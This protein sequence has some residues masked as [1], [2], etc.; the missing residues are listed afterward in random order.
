[1]S[2]TGVVPYVASKIQI[3]LNV[4]L[5]LLAAKSTKPQVA[6]NIVNISLMDLLETRVRR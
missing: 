6:S 4:V 1:M 3:R 5:D 2:T